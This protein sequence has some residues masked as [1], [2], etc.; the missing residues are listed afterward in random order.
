M[1][2]RRD[3]P[4]TLVIHN[5]LKDGR[6]SFFFARDRENREPGVDGKP[7]NI[8]MHYGMES[9][10]MTALEWADQFERMAREIRSHL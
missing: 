10:T 6:L 4:L 8:G 5:V 3:E 1:G 2:I 9:G 7:G